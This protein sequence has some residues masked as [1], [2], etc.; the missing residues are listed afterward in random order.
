MHLV[1]E[2]EQQAA[3]G[4][5]GKFMEYAPHFTGPGTAENSIK[6]MLSVIEKAS[7]E[8]GDGGTFVSE[9]GNKQWL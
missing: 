5:M 2:K 7:V 1:S 8:G 4:M 6:D 3:G 9:K